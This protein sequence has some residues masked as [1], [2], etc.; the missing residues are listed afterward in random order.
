MTNY[1]YRFLK[2]KQ[3][4]IN[5]NRSVTVNCNGFRFVTVFSL[6]GFLIEMVHSR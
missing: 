4:D 1:A 6:F 3:N 5:S 2:I